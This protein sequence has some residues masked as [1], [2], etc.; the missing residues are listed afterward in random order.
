[1]KNAEEITNGERADTVRGALMV[2]STN[3]GEEGEEVQNVR[4]LVTNLCHYMR[5][6]LGVVEPADQIKQAVEM[7]LAEAELDPDE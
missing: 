5:L 2:F 1:M 6:H 7:Y 4:D 3:H